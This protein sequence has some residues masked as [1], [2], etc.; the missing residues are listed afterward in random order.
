VGERKGG[1]AGGREGG[2][3]G[4]QEG[5]RAGGR[6]GGRAGGREG[7]RAGELVSYFFHGDFLSV[8]L[9]TMHAVHNLIGLF[10]GLHGHKCK[11]T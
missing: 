11:T 4:G 9:F 5:G 6:E 10:F 8:N 3:A 1:R 2:R 7:G